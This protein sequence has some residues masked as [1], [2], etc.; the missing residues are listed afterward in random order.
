MIPLQEFHFYLASNENV[1]F[2]IIT[3]I[4]KADSG[5]SLSG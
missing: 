3:E 2:V 5:L 4:E 1:P